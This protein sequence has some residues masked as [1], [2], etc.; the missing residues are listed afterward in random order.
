MVLVNKS[1]ISYKLEMFIPKERDLKIFSITTLH[2]PHFQN[3]LKGIFF[4]TLID[5]FQILLH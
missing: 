3:N 4:L 5:L 2:N 1:S